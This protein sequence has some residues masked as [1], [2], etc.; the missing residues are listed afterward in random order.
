MPVIRRCIVRTRHRTKVVAQCFYDRIRRLVIQ[1]GAFR[2]GSTFCS[3]A[4]S[5]LP[6]PE[7]NEQLELLRRELTRIVECV[8]VQL[9]SPCSLK[10]LVVDESTSVRF[11]NLNICI[12]KEWLRPNHSHLQVPTYTYILIL[13]MNLNRTQLVLSSKRRCKC[14]FDGKTVNVSRQRRDSR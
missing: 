9:M 2:D 8:V 10:F 1:P 13:K 12:I 14:V 11:T 3:T 7:K 6:C 5:I 4:D